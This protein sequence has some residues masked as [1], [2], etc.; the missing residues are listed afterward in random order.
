[1]KSSFFIITIILTTDLY[2]CG[3]TI[4]P[5]EIS[6]SIFRNQSFLNN[7][8][9]VDTS[10]KGSL[11]T[12]M[13]KEFS[14]NQFY[15]LQQNNT[16]AV[17]SM[18][19]TDSTGEKLNAYLYYGF[20]STWK[21]NDLRTF[22]FHYIPLIK[23]ALEKATQLQIDS[24]VAMAKKE[25]HR[26]FLF[27][28]QQEYENRLNSYRFVCG[29]DSAFVEYFLLK[30]TEFEKLKTSIL[31][32]VETMLSKPKVKPREYEESLPRNADI[33]F[34]DSF[35]IQMYILKLEGIKYGGNG[36]FPGCIAFKIMQTGDYSVGYF[37]V[38]DE[39]NIP[40]INPNGLMMIRKIKNGWYLYR[41]N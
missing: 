41:T 15:L 27:R 36:Y 10:Y 33:Y 13:L 14:F 40:N 32:K 28:T 31:P 38:N 24:I 19:I 8:N 5:L 39:R 16:G 17:V 7:K 1:M 20:D 30:E 37:Y 29:T 22:E 35:R 26:D 18:V 34:D 23:K 11:D 12:N 6:Q 25:E 4:G 21:L 3:Q 2:S 9:F